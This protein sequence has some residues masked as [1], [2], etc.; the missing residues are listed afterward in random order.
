[1]DKQKRFL[2]VTWDF[3]PLSEM[4]LQHAVKISKMV[5]TE[6]RLLHII[7][8]KEPPE[9]DAEATSRL[10]AVA[11]KNMK[12]TG[13]NTVCVV[14]RGR[15]F[16]E[17]SQYASDNKANMVIMG[18][19]GIKGSQKLFGSWAMRVILGSKV[20]FLVVQDPPKDMEKYQNIV[21]PV[22]FRLENR[23]KLKMAIFMGKYFESKVHILK[24]AVT[25]K[26]LLKKINTNLNF[27]IKYLLQNNI[28]Y[29]IHDVEKG[30]HIGKETIEFARKINADLIIILTSRQFNV[31]AGAFEQ[32]IIANSLKIPV[33]CINPKAMFVRVGSFQYG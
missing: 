18:T 25:D 8:K 21:F 9:K 5:D 26:F 2:V 13:I 6:I 19:H 1:M 29:E 24:A 16:T 31:V 10:Q 27:A 22:D 32:Y 17:I 14:I 20:P 4:A 3:T 15:I 12:E 23:E 11:E 28:A 30:K 7:G 33:M